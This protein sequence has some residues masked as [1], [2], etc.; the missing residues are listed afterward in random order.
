M[1]YD[2]TGAAS[3]VRNTGLGCAGRAFMGALALLVSGCAAR[4]PDD[5]ALRAGQPVKPR[6][7][8]T[9]AGPASEKK[10]TLRGIVVDRRTGEV[11]IEGEV[12]IEQGILEYL[13]VA[14]HGKAY[15][16]LFQLHCHPSQLHAAMLMA[17]YVAGPVPP[18]LR[19]DFAAETATTAPARPQG[20]PRVPPPPTGYWD[21]TKTQPTRV[22][23]DVEVRQADGTWR[24][25]PVEGFLIDRGHR[26]P[27][28]PLTWAFTGSFFA[29]DEETG[30]E[31]FIADVERS[32]IALWY[33][34]TAL[35]N[36]LRDVGN[37][38]RGES[39]GLEANRADL[40]PVGTP[41][42]LILRPVP[43]G[44]S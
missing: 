11:Q 12:C 44:R 43:A 39:S 41:V 8:S 25:R 27:P 23:I 18:E 24:P 34:P 1:P 31:A 10:V 13:A 36:L 32:L 5:M 21:R 3:M 30:R 20:A 17:G 42:R 33:D 35:L 15:E 22:R 4:G 19:G 16:S 26:R 40:P 7:A 38:Y 6:P 37:P 29:R 2:P 14:D 9:P 28:A